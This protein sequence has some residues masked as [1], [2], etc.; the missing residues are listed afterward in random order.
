MKIAYLILAH[1]NPTHFHRLIQ[2]LSSEDV[3]FYVHID[4]KADLSLFRG[5]AHPRLRFCEER[6]DCAWGDISLV[7]ATL[8]LVKMALEDETPC[9]YFVLLSGACYSLQP[10][11]YIDAFLT[12]RKGQEFIEV[13]AMPNAE[14]GKP[15][16]RLTHFWIRKSKPLLG[17]KWRLQRLM[18][19]VIVARDYKKGLNG[20]QPMVGSQWWALSREALTFITLF[21]RNNPRFYQFCKNIDC[22]DEFVFQTILWNSPFKEKISHSLTYTHWLPGK[23]GPE[24]IDASYFPVFRQPVI[25]DSQQNNCPNEKHE[26]L[27]TRKFTHAAGDLLDKMDEIISAKEGLRKSSM[28]CVDMR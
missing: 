12:A 11:G 14:Y 18:N 7:D 3:Y 13:F 24:N 2:R 4:A 9:D 23:V 16:Q 28:L 26:V 17:L 5:I 8:A 6:K 20:A 21:L 1:N 10:T 22:P 25:C 19:K 15:M 27:F